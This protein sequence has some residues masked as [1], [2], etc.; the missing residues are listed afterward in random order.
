M[1]VLKVLNLNFLKS[2]S[3]VFEIITSLLKLQF[4]QHLILALLKVFSISLLCMLAP[5]IL[6]SYAEQISLVNKAAYEK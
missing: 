4:N 5:V 6:C 2:K 1:I 3:D